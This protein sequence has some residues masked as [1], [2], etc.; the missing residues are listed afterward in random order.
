MFDL[1]HFAPAN[2]KIGTIKISTTGAI[3]LFYYFLKELAAQNACQPVLI[4]K[5]D[6]TAYSMNLNCVVE[7]K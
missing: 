2:F 5:F 1:D 7:G 6:S 3:S 4:L